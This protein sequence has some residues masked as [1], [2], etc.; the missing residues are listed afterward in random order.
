MVHMSRYDSIQSDLIRLLA[1]YN[2]GP[3][4]AA[5]WGAELRHMGDPLLFLESIPLDE[6]RAYVPRVLAYTW[7]Y[8]AR[9]GLPSPSLD[10]LAAG[11]WP[12]FH[13]GAPR[14]ALPA[15]SR[16]DTLALN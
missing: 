10:E 9:M 6:T 8:A 4:S 3:T 15:A 16:K 2:A 13:P 7:L 12:R 11:T 5:R 14:Q 1:S